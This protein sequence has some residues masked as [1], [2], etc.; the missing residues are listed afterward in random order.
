[1]AGVKTVLKLY[2]IAKKAGDPSFIKSAQKA[3]VLKHGKGLVGNLLLAKV[4]FGLVPAAAGLGAAAIATAA[5]K[6]NREIESNGMKTINQQDS[7]LNIARKR[8]QK[9]K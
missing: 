6:A 8:N 1:M 4:P 7:L 2:E 3:G 5:R 9:K